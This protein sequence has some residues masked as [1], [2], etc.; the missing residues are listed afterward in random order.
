MEKA[1]GRLSFKDKAGYAVGDLGAN[2]A[3]Q[4][5]KLLLIYFYT[6]IYGLSPS[7]AGFIY[8]ASRV[9]DAIN[10]PIMGYISDQTE[11]RWG[12]FRPYMLFGAIPLGISLVL[13]FSTPD[14]G[15]LRSQ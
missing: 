1:R 5:V 13:T 4:M 14:F 8:L 2:F 11:S 12:K 3:W 9:W 10:D 15:G 7:E 6:D